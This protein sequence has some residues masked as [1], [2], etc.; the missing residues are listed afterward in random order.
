MKSYKS[1]L[2]LAPQ[3]MQFTTHYFDFKSKKLYGNSCISNDP[4]KTN[5]KYAENES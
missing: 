5:R 4:P 1:T 2:F 3:H